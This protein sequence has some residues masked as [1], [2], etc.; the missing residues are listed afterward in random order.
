MSPARAS[1]EP[2][3]SSTES[4]TDPPA[5]PDVAPAPAPPLASEQQ[6]RGVVD[7]EHETDEEGEDE[8]DEAGEE[9]EDDEDE[10]GEYTRTVRAKWTY[11][12][13]CTLDEVIERLL[14]EA[15][16]YRQLRDE[17]WE[18]TGAVEDDY[19]FLHNRALEAR[20]RER[21]RRER[22]AARAPPPP[23]PQG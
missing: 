12:G 3:A 14:S 6:Q 9:D 16:Y 5:A 23:P 15:D 4:R 21:R 19:G 17:G 22:A 11:D 13:A 18:L 7:Q 10:D 8:T 20:V 1:A 2:T